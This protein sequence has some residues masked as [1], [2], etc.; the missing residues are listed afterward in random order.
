LPH[1]DVVWTAAAG[2]ATQVALGLG[3]PEDAGPPR[4]ASDLDR[5]AIV[6]YNFPGSSE[7]PATISG[8]L[9]P[10][11]MSWLSSIGYRHASRWPTVCQRLLAQAGGRSL[12]THRDFAGKADPGPLPGSGFAGT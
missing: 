6:A 9:Q 2:N 10:K 8:R 3:R 4:G 7:T 5:E 11:A 12:S 1:E